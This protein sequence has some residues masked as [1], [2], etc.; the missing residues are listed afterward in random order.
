VV[1]IGSVK[2]DKENQ[3]MADTVSMA[4]AEL[5]CKRG[6]EGGPLLYQLVPAAAKGPRHPQGRSKRA[7]GALR[8]AELTGNG[9]VG[10]SQAEERSPV[11]QSNFLTWTASAWFFFGCQDRKENHTNG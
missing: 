6:Q 1:P 4:P 7:S 10:G 8:A 3:T 5:P 9:G 2:T 11:N